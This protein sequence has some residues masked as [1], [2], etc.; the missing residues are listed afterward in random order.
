ML[1]L[2]D[3]FIRS[4]ERNGMLKAFSPHHNVQLADDDIIRGVVR[5]MVARVVRIVVGERYFT[6]LLVL[7]AASQSTKQM[8]SRPVQE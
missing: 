5:I 2:T 8:R 7:R 4:K 1:P 6:I 3:E